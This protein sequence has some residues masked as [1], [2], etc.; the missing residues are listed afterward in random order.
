MWV[1]PRKRKHSSKLP[2]IYNAYA[3]KL[4]LDQGLRVDSKQ[5]VKL[6]SET[7]MRVLRA[8]RVKLMHRF[9][10]DVLKDVYAESIKI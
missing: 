2:K 8:L 6:Q 7:K 4:N 9:C 10:K 1:L 5:A 3:N